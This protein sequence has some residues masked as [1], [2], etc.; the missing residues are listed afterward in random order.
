MPSTCGSLAQCAQLVLVFGGTA[1]LQYPQVLEQIRKFYPAAHIFG[2]STAG[3]ICGTRRQRHRAGARDCTQRHRSQAWWYAALRE[4]MRQRHDVLDSFADQYARR[5][6]R[7]DT[8]RGVSQRVLFVD[9][10]PQLLEAVERA[11]RKQ[12]DLQTACGSIASGVGVAEPFRVRVA[13]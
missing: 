6:G 3:E 1:V 5:C 2:C 11:L 7:Q 12:V 4:R 13:S 9:D 8:G 10:E